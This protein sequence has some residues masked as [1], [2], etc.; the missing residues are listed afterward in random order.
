MASSV[1]SSDSS[2]KGSKPHIDPILQNALRYTV[3]AREY[4]LLHEYLLSRTSATRKRTPQPRRYE[5]IVE[6]QSG[7][8]F[9]VTT[10]RLALRIFTAA[11]VGFQGW[12]YVMRRITAWRQGSRSRQ[13]TNRGTRAAS[14]R[15]SASLALIL[16][17]H[18]L[19]HRFLLRLRTSLL[20]AS[21][22]PF[23]RR[24]PRIAQILTS[25]HYP[26]IGAALSGLSLGIC[27]KSQLRI[28]VAIYTFSRALEFAY[29]AAEEMGVWGA[30]GKPSWLGSWLIMPFACAQLLHAFVF[31]RDCFPANYGSSILKRS[32]EYVQHRPSTYPKDK[33]WPSELQV[34]DGLAILSKSRWPA[35]VSPILFPGARQS[36]PAISNLAPIYSPAHPSTQ[37]T[38]CALLH[39]HD[40]SCT[41]T[42]LKYFLAAFPSNART[43]TVL[44]ATFALFSWKSML[45]DPKSF[46]N[47]LALRILRMTLFLTGA[48]GTSWGSICLFANYLPRNFL[49]TQRWLLS[50]FLGGLFAFVARRGERSTFL[51]SARLSIDSL[52]KVGIKRGWWRGMKGGDVILFTTSL[53]LI[54]VL[55]TSRPDAVKGALIRRGLDVL[56]APQPDGCP[57]SNT[58]D[59]QGDIDG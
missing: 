40:P 43:F 55:Y 59:S 7:S 47:S 13:N 48:I 50:G 18:R 19:L 17:F 21:A 58:T 24:N 34:V 22:S 49:A 31:D 54:N 26:A 5:A 45:A 35:F 16:V 30:R 42:Y 14:C 36:L 39:P 44:Y 10:V 11:Y 12:D 57:K 2:D 33:F 20:E 25:L 27:P 6:H 46:L 41:R 8:D 56:R 29:N 28:S 38:S 23:R 4:R 32:P 52:W 37:H 15:I 53:A 1:S 3:S 9:N 51:Y